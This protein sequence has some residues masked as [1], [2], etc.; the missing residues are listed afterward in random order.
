MADDQKRMIERAKEA[1]LVR[2][3]K[4]SMLCVK[5]DEATESESGAQ[6]E[7]ADLMEAAREEGLGNEADAINM[8]SQQEKTH[9]E[10]LDKM[11]KRQC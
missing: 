7:Y 11:K 4:S 9:Q 8:I 5:L 6:N 3:P 1:G 2:K 10:F